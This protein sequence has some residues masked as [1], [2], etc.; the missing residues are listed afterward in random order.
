MSSRTGEINRFFESFCLERPRSGEP[1]TQKQNAGPHTPGPA[2]ARFS[3]LTNQ[4]L[5]SKNLQAEYKRARFRKGRCSP[6]S[7]RCEY[8]LFQQVTHLFRLV[9]GRLAGCAGAHVNCGLRVL[10]F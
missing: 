7:G 8:H 1:I 2:F 4:P 3:S 9:R 5:Y 6:K 10:R